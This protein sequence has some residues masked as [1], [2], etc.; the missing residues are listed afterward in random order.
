[1]IEMDI[2]TSV[3]YVHLT[4]LIAREDFIKCAV[5]VERRE[6]S[7]YYPKHNGITPF[8]YEKFHNVVEKRNPYKFKNRRRRPEPTLASLVS[9]V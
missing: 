1:M 2:E 9:G 3:Y 5:N 4:R 7:L 6:D 8:Y